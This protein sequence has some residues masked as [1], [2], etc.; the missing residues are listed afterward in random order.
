MRDNVEKNHK[1][2]VPGWDDEVEPAHQ[3]ARDAYL[4]WREFGKPRT[5]PIYNVMKQS[6]CKFKYVLRKC[7]RNKET[8]IADKLANKFSSKSDREFWKDVKNIMNSKVKLPNLIGECKGDD[9]PDMWK[10]HYE[11][12]FNSVENSNCTRFLSRLTNVPTDDSMIVPANEIYDII[13]V[14]NSVGNRTSS[15]STRRYRS[16]LVLYPRQRRLGPR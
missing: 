5:G 12:I 15:T 16:W 8:I 10:N 1:Y 3:A 13:G 4:M 2:N 14:S 7:K 9:I 6:R 11:N